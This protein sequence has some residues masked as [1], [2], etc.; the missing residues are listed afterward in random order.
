[1]PLANHASTS[2]N[3]DL[4]II[5]AFVEANYEEYNEER[6]MEPRLVRVRE[7]TPVLRIGSLHVQR[8]RRRVV[9]FEDSS[10][11]DGSRV[12]RESDGR[13]PSER[14]AK[15]GGSHGVNLPLLLVA[16]LGR[17]ESEQPL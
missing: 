7:T 4:M 17:S 2:A 16:H 9:E 3:P 13:R 5:S 10:N 14:R 6:E 15:D 8:H 11:R 12:E 1:M